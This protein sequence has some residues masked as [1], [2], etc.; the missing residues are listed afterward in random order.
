MPYLTFFVKKKFKKIDV[1][2]VSARQMGLV[3]LDGTRLD[4]LPAFGDDLGFEAFVLGAQ[5]NELG[6][7]RGKFGLLCLELLL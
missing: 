6:L 4:R 5:P 2:A 7:H 3:T 1:V